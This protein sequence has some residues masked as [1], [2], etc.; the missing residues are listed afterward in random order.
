MTQRLD[1][2]TAAPRAI[3]PLF[4]MSK[5]IAAS[6]LDPKL[7]L[8]VQLR[9]SQI[10]G[11]AFCLALHVKE[12]TA[13]GEPV[14]RITSLDAWRETPWYSERERMAIE[15]TEALVTISRAHPSED[16]LARACAVQRCGTRPFNGCRQYHHG[17]E[18]AK[19][20]FPHLA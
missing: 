7:V 11:C 8:F 16:L 2:Q 19:R 20:R 4:E 17:M 18:S 1:Y 3:R 12:A 15:W 9:A 13:L 14:E 5:A 10:N 6:G